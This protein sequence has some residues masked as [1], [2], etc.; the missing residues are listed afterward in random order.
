MLRRHAVPASRRRAAAGL[1]LL[2]LVQ[3]VA[4]DVKQL[5][6]S[7]LGQ[8]PVWVQNRSE[9]IVLDFR[10]ADPHYRHPNPGVVQVRGKDMRVNFHIGYYHGNVAMVRYGTSFILAVRKMH[11][12]KTLRSAIENYPLSTK[13][14]GRPAG[15]CRGGQQARSMRACVTASSSVRQQMGWLIQ[16]V[17]CSLRQSW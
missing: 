14:G 11:F 17:G 16:A 6:A 10:K 1:S 12:Y 4:A 2:L 15:R 3:V 7:V 13:K 8:Q 5:S 9:D